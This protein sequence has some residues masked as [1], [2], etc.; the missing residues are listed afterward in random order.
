MFGGQPSR[1]R[2][3]NS[4]RPFWRVRRRRSA[5]TIAATSAT[6][7]SRKYTPASAQRQT[8]AKQAGIG[9]ILS[10]LLVVAPSAVNDS[11]RRTSRCEWQYGG[12][13]MMFGEEIQLF[14]YA[15][16]STDDDCRRETTTSDHLCA[17][18]RQA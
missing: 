18:R 16:H 3:T 2:L 7:F 13:G 5:V 11:C 8:P 12:T 1:R 9:K 4:A 15:L 14:K 17:H 10:Q 6:L